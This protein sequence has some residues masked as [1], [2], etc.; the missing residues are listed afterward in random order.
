MG[1]TSVEISCG[2]FSSERFLYFRNPG[3]PAPYRQQR[4]CRVRVGKHNKSVCQY[5]VDLLTFD[6]APPLYGNCSQDIFVVSGQN[7]NNVVPKICGRNSG[8]H[9]E[10]LRA[11][12]PM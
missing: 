10:Y 6:L 1:E 7:E 12:E 9:C 4:M 11:C 3:F 8:Q 2:D 5:R